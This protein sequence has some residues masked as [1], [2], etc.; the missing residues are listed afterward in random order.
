MPNA[1]TIVLDIL[2]SIMAV[3]TLRTLEAL[4]HWRIGPHLV[5]NRELQ[6]E[7]HVA[8]LQQEVGQ[9][10]EQNFE[11][12]RRESVGLRQIAELQETIRH[13]SLE[14]D[15]L[16]TGHERLRQTVAGPTRR[17]L[18][19]LGPDPRFQIDLAA[20]RAVRSRTGM[21]FL[22]LTGVTRELLSSHLD[23]SRLNGRP[24]AHVHLGVHGTDE[25]LAF[26]DG[27]VSWNWLSGTLDGIQVLLLASCS[28]TKVGD[29]L[30]VVPWVVSLSEGITLEDGARFTQAFWSEIGNG[31]EPP[32][33]L[34]A[35][36][37]RSP[38]QMQEFVIAHW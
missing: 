7:R 30:G 33:A 5:T 34:A 24:F 37:E 22:R 32:L 28:S 38:A 21:E 20:L 27:L 13:L 35:A 14:L 8:A 36:L 26:R 16:R 15:N 9:L 18:V 6:L 2:L 10:K 25:G 11:A 1:L 17:L 3:T 29:W 12:I 19:A 23:R 4:F 31:V